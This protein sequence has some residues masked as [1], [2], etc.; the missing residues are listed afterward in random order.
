MNYEAVKIEILSKLR[1]G[2]SD[3]L[4]Y[5]NVNHTLS[6]IKA[7]AHL[8]ALMNV[9]KVETDILLTA[10]L[11]HDTGYLYQYDDNEE[12]G[13]RLAEKVLP[14]FSYSPE[15]IEQVCQI[16]CETSLKV[17]CSSFLSKLVRDADLSY[18]GTN[19]YVETAGTLRKEFLAYG[20]S[21]DDERWLDLQIDFLTAHKFYT[22]AAV[23]LYGE[24]KQ[25]HLKSLIEKKGRT[26]E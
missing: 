25:R 5:H 13:A 8:S 14:E 24:N 20:K 6:V 19:G 9:S 3:Q 10:A 12:I 21:L 18:L 2:L 23:S 4:F 17:S 7:T 22:S 11:F 15:Q 26:C 16:I 1:R